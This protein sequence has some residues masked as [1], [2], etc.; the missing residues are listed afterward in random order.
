MKFFFL[1]SIRIY[2][3]E[4]TF[5]TNFSFL[6]Y[7]SFTKIQCWILFLNYLVGYIFFNQFKFW[8]FFL[9]CSNCFFRNWFFLSQLDTVFLD[10]FSIFWNKTNKYWKTITA[11]IYHSWSYLIV[12]FNWDFWTLTFIGDLIILTIFSEISKLF[13]IYKNLRFSAFLRQFAW[14]KEGHL[15]HRNTALICFALHTPSHSF[16]FDSFKCY[17]DFITSCNV[18]IRTI[19]NNFPIFW[20]VEWMS[21]FVGLVV[22]IVGRHFKVWTDIT[23]QNKFRWCICTTICKELNFSLCNS[24]FYNLPIFTEDD[25]CWYFWIG[26]RSCRPVCPTTIFW[27]ISVIEIV[28]AVMRVFINIVGC[29]SKG[30]ITIFIIVRVIWKNLTKFVCH[31]YSELYSKIAT[32]DTT[33]NSKL[34]CFCQIFCWNFFPFNC[35]VFGFVAVFTCEVNRNFSWQFKRLPYL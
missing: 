8:K 32:K 3:C 9:Y 19:R 12:F 26:R 17:V 33:S 24:P 14:S 10:L 28:N 11:T 34:T 5:L 4:D 25:A 2:R 21:R 23:F 20:V 18:F 16:G 27:M 31:S 7:T 22:W 15:N 29:W 35:Q 1:T 30:L 6:F 13:S